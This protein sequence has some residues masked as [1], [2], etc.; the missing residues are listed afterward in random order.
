MVVSPGKVKQVRAEVV[1]GVRIYYVP[2]KNIYFP[3][4]T[5]KHRVLKAVWHV[6]DTYNPLMVGA[7]AHVLDVERPEVVNTHNVTGFSPI[8]WR[9]VKERGIAIVNTVHSYYLLCPRQLMRSGG[10]CS[11]LCPEC[12]V[13][14]Y[15]RRRL[16]ELVDVATGVSK[17]IIQRYRQRGFFR[18]AKEFL[19]YNGVEHTP[20]SPAPREGN[21]RV[22]LGYLGRLHPIKGVEEL[23][24]SFLGLPPGQAELLIAGNGMP[25]YERVLREVAG[26]R[27][28]IHW[29]GYVPGHELLRQVDVLV[30][31]SLWHDPAPLVVQEALSYG[32]PVIGARR[33]GIPELMGEG[34]GWIF[35]PEEPGA[36]T[37]AMWKA[38]ESRCDLV[39]MGE[40][41]RKWV[42]NFTPEAM[43][44]GYVAAYAYAVEKNAKTS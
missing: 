40:R 30:V 35:E 18:G 15:P 4:D 42:R 36:L 25:E 26:V 27:N 29:L 20:K 14:R 43:V 3:T 11:T 23:I 21:G 9:V 6:L 22:R 44:N 12:C 7:L 16:S 10:P 34:T 37:R 2:V 5:G 32:V 19:I 13:L 38:V 1:N 28:E 24:R 31:P 17:F 33:G 41:A 8:L 39:T